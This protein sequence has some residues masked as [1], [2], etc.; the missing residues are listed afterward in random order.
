MKFDTLIIG[1]GLAG[2]LC[3][4]TLSQRGLRCAIISRGQNGL[5]FSS[6]SLDLLDAPAG[7]TLEQSLAALAGSHPEHPYS[8]IGAGQVIDYAC[9]AE[10]LLAGCGVALQGGL[11]NQHQR[12]TPLGGLKRAWLSPE[13]A[14]I[15]PVS[16][17]RI[18]V[19]GISGFP[20]FQAHLAAPALC[21]A[22]ALADAIDI[23][24]PQLDD[25]RENASEF[26]S[27][28]IARL[29]DE[30]SQWAAL[31][32]A[33]RPIAERYDRLLFPACFGLQNSQLWRWL[34][35][36]LPCPLALLPTL[37]PSVPG[38]RMH[39]A[40]Q[41]HF[42]RLGGTWLAGDEVAAVAFDGARV[43]SVST[44]N[45]GDVPL[46]T[47]FA[48]LASGG[49][50]SSGLVARRDKICEPV[51]NL[52]ITPLLSRNAWY[53]NDFFDSQPWQR[54]GVRT[55]ASLRG[56]REGQQIDNLYAIGGILGGFDAIAQ[57][58]GGGVSAITA[59]HAARQISA[60]AGGDA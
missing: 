46:Q 1:G 24:L 27:V 5:H 54:C 3:G 25:L 13:E 56:Q 39:T 49:F 31:L 33:L 22:G 30:K 21:K 59:L 10:K 60:L 37:P 51:F 4:I 38:I 7:E 47:R 57:G 23:E 11:N 18:A 45:H 36:Q 40:L 35:E 43:S 20:D 42:V 14:P 28:N 19:V 50:F 41:R 48:V 53:N 12:I 17:E 55:D 34:S 15:G 44:R 58:C 6:G 32:G 26:R 8:L 2:L 29:L 52:D 9:Q 16:G